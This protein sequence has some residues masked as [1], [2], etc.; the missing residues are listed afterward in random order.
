MTD[1]FQILYGDV[2]WY[3]LHIYTFEPCCPHCSVLYMVK[4]HM[5]FMRCN[6]HISW[7]IYFKF[8]KEVCFC[9]ICTS[10]VFGDAAPSLDNSPSLVAISKCTP[11][12]CFREGRGELSPSFGHKDCTKIA[13]SAGDT[14]TLDG[15]RDCDI[16]S[17]WLKVVYA[18]C[19]FHF[20]TISGHQSIYIVHCRFSW[21]T[22]LSSQGRIQPTSRKGGPIREKIFSD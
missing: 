19:V 1:F 13:A 6:C 21:A 7:R 12:F 22:V 15:N 4:S 20:T 5:S 17:L 3:N 8:C 9:K 14:F 10:I 2:S 18:I 11:S 16:S